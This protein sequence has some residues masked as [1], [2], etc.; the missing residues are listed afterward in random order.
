MEIRQLNSFR[1]IVQSGSLEDA[2]I[3]LDLDASACFHVPTFLRLAMLPLSFLIVFRLF[4]S[5]ASSNYSVP[6]RV[7]S[8]SDETGRQV[9]H[10][11]A[12]MF[13]TGQ[14]L[15]SDLAHRLRRARR[16]SSLF[17]G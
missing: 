14:Y 6:L 8:R 17:A 5:Q 15:L 10:F 12:G 2:D 3:A 9:S 13:L 1:W 4:T 7:A 16:R 11:D